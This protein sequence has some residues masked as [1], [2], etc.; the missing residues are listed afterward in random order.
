MTARETAR[1]L[2]GSGAGAT[3][4]TLVPILGGAA[5]DEAI[6]AVGD[7]AVA[8]DSIVARDGAMLE[9]G[10]IVPT[11]LPKLTAVHTGCLMAS[12]SAI[13]AATHPE[14]DRA[15]LVATVLEETLLAAAP[16]HMDPNIIEALVFEGRSR[17]TKRV[18][19]TSAQLAPLFE[20][21]RLKPLCGLSKTSASFMKSSEQLAPP[22]P[23]ILNAQYPKPPQRMDKEQ[24]CHAS[25]RM[26]EQVKAQ[27]YKI[28]K[29]DSRAKSVITADQFIAAK[30]RT[31]IVGRR[32]LIQFYHMNDANDRAG[33]IRADQ[34]LEVFAAINAVTDS[35]L[36]TTI[37]MQYENA[38]EYFPD[39][40][41]SPFGVLP[42]G[43]AVIVSADEL[44]ENI[45][46]KA[47]AVEF[48]KLSVRMVPCGS[49]IDTF[50]ITNSV[51]FAEVVKDVSDVKNTE[52]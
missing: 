9:S 10:A 30:L 28:S 33:N 49:R 47:T 34:V 36:G 23:P 45:A 32:D 37:R 27:L 14:A 5:P 41:V 50:S 11:R 8:G 39:A 52:I 26:S 12:C 40:V 1:T 38:L 24:H 17:K 3:C 6:V 46:H 21:C 35:F 51:R 31:P 43:P 4:D 2:P 22:L 29:A 15:A 20:H 42:E 25:V 18:N 7:A 16:G 48:Y 13:V 19:P 44:A